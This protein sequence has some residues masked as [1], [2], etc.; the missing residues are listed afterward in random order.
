MGKAGGHV[1]IGSG[2]F[3]DMKQHGGRK[4]SD[5]TVGEVMELQRDDGS[6][7]DQQWIDQGKIWAAGR[8]QFVGPTL[9]GIVGQMGIDPSTRFSPELQDKMAMYLGKQNLDNLS[10]TW[11]GL[12]KLSPQD[13][14][15]V[16][17]GLQ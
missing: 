1:A 13:L 14:A 9:S 17:A 5:L 2:A 10:N 3:G 15:R 6:L 16:R 11:I 12:Q 7:T 4:L 8:Y